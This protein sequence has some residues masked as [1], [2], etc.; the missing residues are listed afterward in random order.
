MKMGL[1]MCVL[2]MPVMLLYFRTFCVGVL[3]ALM[4]P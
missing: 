4:L 2:F 1:C 3:T